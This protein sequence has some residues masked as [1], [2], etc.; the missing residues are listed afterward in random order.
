MPRG[1]S[2]IRGSAGLP[3][4]LDFTSPKSCYNPAMATKAK[5]PAKRKAK[6]G[7]KEE[8]LK[9][10]GNWKANIAKTLQAKPSGRTK[11]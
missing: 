3:D 8:V 11:S 5:K 9:L 4:G 2:S 6:P 10:E 7:P 1:G